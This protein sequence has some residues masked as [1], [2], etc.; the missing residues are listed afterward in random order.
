[1]A[2][3]VEYPLLTAE[4]FLDIDFGDRKAELDDGVIRTMAS[5]TARHARVQFNLLLAP[6]APICA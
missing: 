1:V 3:V 5:G 2:T 6:R 4:D